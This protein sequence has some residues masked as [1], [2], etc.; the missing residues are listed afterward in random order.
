MAH[1]DQV[2]GEIDRIVLRERTARPKQVHDLHRHH[3]LDLV[4][5]GTGT[6]RPVSMDV[7]RIIEL[8]VSSFSG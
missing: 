8:I 2:R 3:I 7:P 6:P 4:L 1:E 5:A